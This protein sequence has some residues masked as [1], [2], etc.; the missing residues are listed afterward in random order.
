MCSLV[1]T[2]CAGPFLDCAVFADG[3]SRFSR[4]NCAFSDQGALLVCTCGSPP[5]YTRD[6]FSSMCCWCCA[7]QPRPS[8][9]CAHPLVVLTYLRRLE[10]CERAGLVT[11]PAMASASYL[12]TY[13]TDASGVDGWQDV[14]F[15]ANRIAPHKM[16]DRT[17]HRARGE[18]VHAPISDSEWC[19]A[20]Q[21]ISGKAAATRWPVARRAAPASVDN[22]GATGRACLGSGRGPRP[23][24]RPVRAARGPTRLASGGDTDT[25]ERESPMPKRA[26]ACRGTQWGKPSP[27]SKLRRDFPESTLGPMTGTASK[28]FLMAPVAVGTR[29][30]A[31]R[32]NAGARDTCG[33]VSA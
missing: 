4:M 12:S 33:L 2:G 22:L 7:H 28:S 14:T 32:Q 6:A 3:I 15:A 31:L 13:L 18:E 25:A 24:G 17:G 16:A 20:G 1:V 19:P 26:T 9:T 8:N 10:L 5:A 27:A 11:S 29:K 23:V 21:G 30:L